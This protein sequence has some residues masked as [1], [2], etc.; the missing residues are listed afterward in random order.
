M[1][2][3][4]T[5]NAAMKTSLPSSGSQ[6][7]PRLRMAVLKAEQARRSFKEFVNQ[8]WRVLEPS[9]A[10]V[11]GAHIDAICGHLQ[12]VTEGKIRNLIIN[13]PPGHAK[14]LLVCVFWPAWVWINN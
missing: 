1:E 4:T 7:V 5:N 2:Q 11:Q 12:A 6:N 9:T 14:S 10:F 13:V 3:S 8:A